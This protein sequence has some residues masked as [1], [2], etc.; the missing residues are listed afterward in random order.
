MIVNDWAPVA[1]TEIHFYAI[2]R[3]HQRIPLSQKAQVTSVK[4]QGGC[5]FIVCDYFCE[6]IYIPEEGYWT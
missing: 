4:S 5:G 2:H 3:H 6:N 1:E